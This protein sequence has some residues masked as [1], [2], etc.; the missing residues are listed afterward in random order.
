MNEDPTV[1]IDTEGAVRTAVPPASATWGNF[2][3]LARVGVGGFGEVYRAWDPSLQREVALKLLLPGAV[4]GDAEYESVLR[5]ARALASVRHANIVSV[6]GIDR[7]DGR[8][9]FW[10]D[11]VH[12]KTLSV[13]VGEQGRFGAREAAL[14]GLDVTRA[15]SAVHRAGLLH[16]DIKAE[17]VMRE[18][19]GRILL[20]DFG[21]STLNP[22]QAH[23]AGTPNYMAP[24]LFEGQPSTVASDIYAMGVLL[25]YLVAGDFP[26]RL[27]EIS[28]SDVRDAMTRRTP[29]IDVR[30]DLPDSLVR[31]I[32]RAMETDPAK[33]FTSAGQLASEMAESLGTQAPADITAPA[34]L[35]KR[36]RAGWVWLS[37]TSASVVVLA[38]ALLVWPGYLR[39][40]TQ[41]Q[42]L[43]PLTGTTEDQL[44][45][46]QDLLRRSYKLSN[47]AE[48]IKGFDA[49]LKA[50][51]D[52]ALAWARLGQAY[53]IR[54]E[55]DNDPKLLTQATDATNRAIKLDSK[56]AV[57]YI[58][59]SRIAALRGDTQEATQQAERATKLDPHNAETWG[60]LGE[61]YGSQGRSQDEIDAYQRAADLAPDDWRWPVSLGV[62][63]Y[64]DSKLKD[65][66][67][68]LQRGVQ[69]ASDNAAAYFDLAIA[70]STAGQLND[71]LKD[72]QKSIDLEPTARAYSQMGSILTFQG[73]YDEAVAMEKKAIGLSPNRYSEWD[74][75]GDAY[76]W[77]GRHPQEAIKA[78]L[79]AVELE[80]AQRRTKPQNASLAATLAED[81]ARVGNAER[82]QVMIRQAQ[83]LSSDDPSVAFR[84]GEA[85]DT[86]GQRQRAIPLMAQ[87]LAAGYGQTEFERNPALAGLRN[88]PNFSA[89][90]HEAKAKKQ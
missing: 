17:N 1:P 43:T 78:Y 31:T 29:L 48:A 28:A 12:G 56:L 76:E 27:G 4:S 25:Y 8:V 26:V 85:Y 15:L 75:L 34:A 18:E 7:H 80:E 88:D 82:S 30:P 50:E 32:S 20:M 81:Y 33:R 45:K 83:V 3:L 55:A 44:Q 72:V 66:I 65:S 86:L 64:G 57:P 79:K 90:L 9:G 16:R 14:I 62:A 52:S 67:V 40:S 37:A 21:L 60:A 36:N 39:R 11:F 10:T 47:V 71:A 54:Y 46:A 42:S 70:H 13:L 23:T 41:P 5:E 74:N 69:L 51:P 61:V 77:S 58:T 38:L 89:A 22:R 49:V 87:A 24:E 63:L 53:F 84:L 6:Y 59:L 35:R 2:K 68:Q 73:R 19:G